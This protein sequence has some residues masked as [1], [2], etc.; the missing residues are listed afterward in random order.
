MLSGMD[1]D[2]ISG[3]CATQRRLNTLVKFR[4]SQMFSA[5]E[6]AEYMSLVQRES[7][8]L[9]LRPTARAFQQRPIGAARV[10]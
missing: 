3:L 8:L 5:R 2:D 10:S 4:L 7:E 1:H 9:S 6:Y